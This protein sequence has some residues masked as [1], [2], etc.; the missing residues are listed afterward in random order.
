MDDFYFTEGAA[1]FILTLFPQGHVGTC[2][3]VGAYA[4]KW[5]S[6]SYILEQAGWTVHCIEPNPSCLPMLVDRANVY[7]F[8][9][10]RENRDNVDFF[11][12]SGSPQPG[13]QASFTG[14]VHHPGTGLAVQVI[15]VQKRTLSWFMENY[16]EGD[17]L[18]VLSIDA[19]FTDFDVLRSADLDR[20]PTR[21]I[22]IEN[23]NQDPAQQEYLV[24]RGYQHINRIMYNDIYRKTERE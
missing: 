24:A 14:L 7:T 4:S 12:Y 19:E 8:A 13:G 6:N 9:I 20:W 17:T 2:V 11:V 10:G 23:I 21:V 22:C 16:F 1:E 5:L 3:D 18:D 15:K